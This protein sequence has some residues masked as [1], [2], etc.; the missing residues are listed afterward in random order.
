MGYLIRAAREAD[1]EGLCEVFAEVDALHRS[2]EP[3]VFREV[4]GPP[5]TRE[6]VSGLALGTSSALFVAE[7]AE[8]VVGLVQVRVVSEAPDVPML[9]PRRYAVVGDL[10]VREDTR[11]QGIGRAL[12][13]RAHTWAASRGAADVELT[14]WEFNRE[15]RAF[16]ES[17][18][19][20]TARRRMW[21]PLDQ[22]PGAP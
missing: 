10:V 18:G 16:Y 2:S 9:A 1:Y 3:R 4:A 7:C 20:T 21:R 13:D 14:V 17:L 15:A 8:R 11:R 12:L 5:R 6:F 22:S 19:Y